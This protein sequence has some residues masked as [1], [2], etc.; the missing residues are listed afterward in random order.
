VERTVVTRTRR[1]G[2]GVSLAIGLLVLVASLLWLA[3]RSQVRLNR[4]LLRR[5]QRSI[6]LLDRLDRFVLEIQGAVRGFVL[7][8]DSAYLAPY[9]A[10]IYRAPRIADDLEPLLDLESEKAGLRNAMR[11]LGRWRSEIAEPRIRYVQ[12]RGPQAG[13]PE[14]LGLRAGSVRIQSIRDAIAGLRALERGEIDRGS[15]EL[16]ARP[17]KLSQLGWAITLAAGLLL[18]AG[19]AAVLRQYRRRAAR[20]EEGLRRAQQGDYRAL[21]LRG[22]DEIGKTA[23]AF[24]RMIAEIEARDEA[25]RGQRTLL[26]SIL[27]GMS[28]GVVVSDR[29]G[30]MVLRNPAAQRL[31]GVGAGAPGDPA[32]PDSA[33]VLRAEEG[34]AATA[35]EHPLARALR[36]EESANVEI[37]IRRAALPGTLVLRASGSPLLGPRGV[38]EG[39]IAVFRDVTEA[40]R[41]TREA[42]ANQERFEL[43]TRATH[44]V[45]RDWNLLTDSVW[46]NWNFQTRLGHTPQEASRGL[47]SWSDNLHPE[48]RARVLESLDAALARGDRDWTGE[49]RFRRG[50]GT[51]AVVLDR[52]SIVRNEGGVP[53][54]MIA[55]MSEV[56][57][58]RGAEET[59]RE[60]EARYRRLFEENLAG[61][62]RSTAEGQ[63]LECNPAQVRMFGYDSEA[64]LKAVPMA[65]LYPTRQDREAFL[66]RLR[67]KGSVV[68]LEVIYRKKDGSRFHVLESAR[69]VPG[70]SGEPEVLEGT[71]IDLTEIRAAELARRQ[72]DARFRELFEQAAEGILIA[73][74]EGRLVLAN[75]AAREM[76][77]YSEKELTRLRIYDIYRPEEFSS[78][79]ERME[80][81]LGGDP[82]LF[83]RDMRRKDG[84][85]F[86]AE[87][88]VRRLA[89]GRVQGILRDVSDRR[90][91]EEALRRAETM[92]ALASVV[93]GLAHEVRNPLF[94]ISATVDA[95]ELRLRDDA[96]YQRYARPLRESVDRLSRLMRD[97]L[98][99]GHPTRLTFQAIAPG[100]LVAE[101]IGLCTGLASERRVRIEPEPVNGLPRVRADRSRVLQVFVHALEN[102]V[103][104]APPGS[105][106]RVGCR[107]TAGTPTD[108][109]EFLV[110][111]QGAGFPSQDLPR[112]F[113][114]FF[115][116]RSG[117]TGLGLAIARR[118]VEEHSG[119]IRVFNRTEGGGAVS[120]ELPCG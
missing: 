120:I 106:V 33:P 35:G 105:R 52:G 20:L 18:A 116:R 92:G 9:R 97:L 34:S 28:D 84:S 98:E 80:T 103:Q 79:Q 6:D 63:L 41:L 25:L 68:N 88:S 44:D 96:G 111:D 19:S 5:D 59:L 77:G 24:D 23:A 114:P 7:T 42:V 53:V 46:W 118:I 43:V 70:C 86:P 83:E 65:A 93:A 104:H 3:Y 75:P 74:A 54:R 87:V 66:S 22:E 67:E 47:S 101:A 31:L 73:D 14:E 38:V 85:G 26:Q 110:E 72:S 100:D 21:E 89:D 119:S 76:L 109:V 16:E 57:A 78:A 60:S 30:R 37:E 51:Y 91:A 45:V 40:R 11:E 113:D 102:A 112:V 58:Q 69:L 10:G 99:F 27:D 1:V 2:L 117:G 55:S 115:T 39:A 108:R 29:G 90:R 15:A 64:E 71:M 61:V 48:D 94:A 32:W 36:G 13:L 12:G 50:G 82:Q 49:Y 107:R 17:R 81:A 62:F 4:V 8:G 95:L 56:T